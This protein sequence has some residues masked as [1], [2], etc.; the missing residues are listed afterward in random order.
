MDKNTNSVR[1]KDFC[2]I[3]QKKS[4]GILGFYQKD[5]SNFNE[6]FLLP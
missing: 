1:N 2:E 5:C 6:M 3:F 4:D